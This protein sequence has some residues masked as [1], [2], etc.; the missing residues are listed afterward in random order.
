MRVPH[1]LR[2]ALVACLLL[3]AC[4][5]RKIDNTMIVDPGE[6]VRFAQDIQPIFT[7][8]CGGAGC[9][10]DQSI[11]GV[12]LSNYEQVMSSIGV[13]YGEE[14]VVPGNPDAS[15]LVDK[16][17]PNPRFGMRMPLNRAPLTA[18]QVAL[19]RTWIEEGAENN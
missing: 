5:S 9:H 2:L 4:Q 16:I 12:E 17:E 7:S 3:P 10:I 1:L 11:N 13:Q 19:I 14:I 8:S 18:Q 15:P 6:P